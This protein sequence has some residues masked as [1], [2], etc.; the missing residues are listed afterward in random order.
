MKNPHNFFIEALEDSEVLLISKKDKEFAYSN[1]P[2][3]EKLF[4][5]ITKKNMFHFKG[6]G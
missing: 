3:I 4:R 6:G 5:A 1:L 2:K